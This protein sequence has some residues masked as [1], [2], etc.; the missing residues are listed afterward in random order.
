LHEQDRLSPNTRHFSKIKHQSEKVKRYLS[1][2][3][4]KVPTTERNKIR[5]KNSF[6]KPLGGRERGH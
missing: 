4:G 2:H 6:T 5:E 3:G 1:T